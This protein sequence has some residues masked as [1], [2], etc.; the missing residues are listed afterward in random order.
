MNPLFE[1]TTVL[2]SLRSLT[3][4]AEMRFQLHRNFVGEGEGYCISVLDGD[5]GKD[6]LEALAPMGKRTTWDPRTYPRSVTASDWGH[7]LRSLT[8]AGGPEQNMRDQRK[9]EAL[10]GV[11]SRP[12]DV[13]SR[14]LSTIEPVRSASVAMIRASQRDNLDYRVLETHSFGVGQGVEKISKPLPGGPLALAYI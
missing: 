3:L 9:V 8:F 7:S 2:L 1:G 12:F 10:E 5:L 4:D 13:L 11:Y 14:A 6:C